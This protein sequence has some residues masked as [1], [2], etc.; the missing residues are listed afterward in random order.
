M[1]A[2]RF[3]KKRT[4]LRSKMQRSLLSFLTEYETPK[5]VSIHSLT[6]AILLRVIQIIIL[7]YSILYLLLYEQGYQKKDT[8]II[9]SVTLKVK[10]IGY[11]HTPENQNLV[12]DV[13]GEIGKSACFAWKWNFMLCRLYNPTI[14]K[15]R[16]LYQDK[17]LSNGP[18]AIDMS[19]E[20]LVER[21]DVSRRR[22]MSAPRPSAQYERTVDRPMFNIVESV[23][24]SKSNG[25]WHRTSD[26]LVRNGR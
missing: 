20:C 6:L 18:N 11:I 2:H 10:G 14:G 8:A 22:E 9:S 17:L 5:I 7:L 3:S 4:F 24:Q 16:Y 21:S 1:D 12:I 26:R 13:A 19:G 23:Q 15:Q 25:E